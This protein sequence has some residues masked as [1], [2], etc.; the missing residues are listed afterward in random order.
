MEHPALVHMI[1]ISKSFAGTPA[2]TNIDLE[3]KAGEIHAILGENGAG[4]STLMNILTGLYKADTGNIYMRGEKVS[5]H[6]P[7]DAIN[8]G[9]G[10]IHQHFRLVSSMSVADNIILGH[11]DVPFILN[12]QEIHRKIL[13]SA[14]E[15]SIS[16]DP[17]LLISQLSVGE[18]QRVEILKALY[19]GSEVLILDEPTAVLT[20]QEARALFYTLKKMAASG[21]AIIVITHKLREVMEIADRI[22]VLRSGMKVSEVL[23]S[24]VDEHELAKLM[25]G[26]DF[27]KK[28]R[29]KTT[30]PG[31]AVLTL[32]D[33]S[34]MNDKGIV[35]L[36]NIN[37]TI[38]A[39]EILG[40]AGVAGNGQKELCEAIA[41]LRPLLHGSIHILNAKIDKPN[42]LKMIRKGIAYIPDDRLGTGLVPG[43]DVVDNMILKDNYGQE[44][45]SRHLIDYR[46][47]TEYTR[48]VLGRYQV[49]VS[50]I[51]AP[52]KLLSGGNLQRVLFAREIAGE[53]VLIIASYPIRGLDIEATETVHD[54]LLAQKTR[55]AGI[56]LVSEDL[57]EIFKLSDRIAVL[58][59]G[60]IMGVV[61]AGDSTP[62]EIGM[63]MLGKK[64]KED[65][66]DEITH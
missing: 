5:F 25:V 44:I 63:M 27:L 42:P 66:P 17:S 64:R 51:H 37:M 33:I 34:A 24:E 61:Q 50:N 59:E 23:R 43:L 16:I 55:G 26:R 35:G 31:D 62:E 14:E 8:A 60:E 3:V 22:T 46:K 39:G 10:M 11:P 21:K 65:H 4:K 47:A 40:I 54:L 2:N 13:T 38:R 29:Q 28:V 52:V 15:F 48:K 12:K 41:G 49:K 53:P 58:F 19:R 20:P 30:N 6:S 57:E 56:L 32:K 36:K 7:R 45:V 18:Q 9:I 1:G